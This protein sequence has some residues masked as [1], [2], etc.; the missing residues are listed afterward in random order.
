MNV[1]LSVCTVDKTFSLFNI[2]RYVQNVQSSFHKIIQSKPSCFTCF[3]FNVIKNFRSLL[4]LSIVC[5]QYISFFEVL[6]MT[7]LL[8][9]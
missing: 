5:Q 6:Q 9:V 3:I 4:H 2:K 7:A 1:D 8:Q